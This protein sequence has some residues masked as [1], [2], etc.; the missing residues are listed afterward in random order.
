MRRAAALL[1]AVVL[2]LAPAVAATAQTAVPEPMGTTSPLACSKDSAG[3]ICTGFL[4]GSDGVALDVS[5]SLPSGRGPWPLLARTHG[6]SANKD[7]VGGT[8]A[9]PWTRD[10]D[11]R[12]TDAGIAL[13]RY[14]VR[15]WGE[16]W[17]RVHVMDP[18]HEVADLRAL[19][20]DVVDDSGLPIDSSRV[21]LWGTSQGG[22]ISWLAMEKPVWTTPKGRRVKVLTIVPVIPA[23]DI[24]SAFIP[25]GRPDAMSP[26]GAMKLSIMWLLWGGGPVT[27]TRPDRPYMRYED[28]ITTVWTRLTAGEPYTMDDPIVK[29]GIENFA[30]RSIARKKDWIARLH[31]D[32]SLRIPILNIQGWNDDICPPEEG[33]R[34][35]RLLKGIDPD[36]PIAMLLSEFGH[37]RGV[38]SDEA[39]DY[40]FD[41]ARRWFAYWLVGSGRRPAF[42]VTSVA[43]RAPGKP[44]EFDHAV[45]GP[46][47]ESLST[48]VIEKHFAGPAVLV[49]VPDPGGI[50]SD[51]LL[52]YALGSGVV[53]PT[54]S[55][56]VP[57]SAARFEVPLTESMTM[58]GLG[59]VHLTG[60]VAG[61]DAIYAARI[62]DEAPDGSLVL[63]DRGV[64]RWQG[65]P[66]AMDVTI[67]L[68]GN[69]YTFGAGHRLL[70]D[71][72][73]ADAPMWR[74]DNMPSTAVLDSV[75][76][77]LPTRS[78]A[79][80]KETA[81]GQAPSV[82]AG[83]TG[84]RLPA[85]GG[86]TTPVGLGLVAS[87]AW[88][89]FATRARRSR[90]V[91]RHPRKPAVS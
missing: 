20:S 33:L 24:L 53:G 47:L 56:T 45:S 87:A 13:M 46:T 50:A 61:T 43:V 18:D 25:N 36:W 12:F 37:P 49:N 69:H 52:S 74:P 77:R 70:L 8:P 42:D 75:D 72:A 31:T 79:A 54:A 44:Y 81:G 38:M 76:L 63:V 71:V 26:I 22:I 65:S 60:T 29:E 51:S 78:E 35:H 73:N 59:S 55:E 82:V 14:S 7:V 3:S 16:S 11:R 89:V 67:A 23:T 15:G 41:V 66:G 34:M 91:M 62:W 68:Q 86:S 17:G 32:P 30:Y 58:L 1:V 5:L 28:W 85:T 57:G 84:R 21:G 90:A 88:A 64:F 2:V 27:G 80:S 6:W 4:P 19:I 40:T 9:I 39:V 48:D 10:L 83:G